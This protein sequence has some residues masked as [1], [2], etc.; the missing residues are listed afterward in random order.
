MAAFRGS[1]ILH[2]GS[3]KLG[4]HMSKSESVP[5]RWQQSARSEHFRVPY[6]RVPGVLQVYYDPDFE[7]TMDWIARFASNRHQLQ[8]TAVHIQT[9]N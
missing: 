7:G 6:S 5:K 3:L 1:E 4:P 2:L 8:P 9:T